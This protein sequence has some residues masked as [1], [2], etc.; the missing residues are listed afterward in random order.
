MNVERFSF[1]QYFELRCMVV[2]NIPPCNVTQSNGEKVNIPY[3]NLISVLFFKFNM[4]LTYF[5]AIC[6]AWCGP[7]F[8][9]DDATLISSTVFKAI[10]LSFDFSFTDISI[11][12]A[13]DWPY[14]GTKWREFVTLTM[15]Q[16]SNKT[17]NEENLRI[18]GHNNYDFLNRT[19]R[20]VLTLD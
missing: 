3:I 5:S 13:S 17:T 6:M 4:R 11:T 7:I 2:Y 8:N 12:T 1:G 10:G 15:I 9:P 19:I 20:A 14:Y 16:S 18:G